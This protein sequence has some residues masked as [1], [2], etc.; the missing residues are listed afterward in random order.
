MT[1][2]QRK[3]GWRVRYSP[4]WVTLAGL[5]VGA[6]IGWMV[7]PSGAIPFGMAGGTAVGVGLDSVLNRRIN[8]PFENP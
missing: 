8:G 4:G 3:T 7:G 1:E 5:V 6:A 2:P